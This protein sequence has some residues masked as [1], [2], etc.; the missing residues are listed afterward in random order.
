MRNHREKTKMTAADVSSHPVRTSFSVFLSPLS[1][2]DTS[3]L[4][5][6]VSNPA[7]TYFS[8]RMPSVDFNDASFDVDAASSP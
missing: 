8:V 3:Q 1:P 5:D 2:D 7:K 6:I 4:V